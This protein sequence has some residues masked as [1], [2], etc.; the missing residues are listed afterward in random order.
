MRFCALYRQVFCYWRELHDQQQK[1]QEKI[2]KNITDCEP[3]KLTE[4][5]QCRCITTTIQKHTETIS[6]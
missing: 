2:L 4:T 3:H 6:L 5:Q 1:Q